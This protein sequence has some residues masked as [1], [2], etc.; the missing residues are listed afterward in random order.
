MFSIAIHRG[1]NLLECC[2]LQWSAVMSSHAALMA[3]NITSDVFHCHS[4]GKKSPWMLHLAM[5]S[6]D[7][8]T[9]SINGIQHHIWC[10]PLPCTG[11]KISLNAAHIPC[12][13]Q[14]WCPHMQHSWHPTETS[15]LVIYD[16]TFHLHSQKMV[17]IVLWAIYI[18]MLP[19]LIC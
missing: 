16:H 19:S 12:N 9:C 15:D 5:I 13:D 8:L 3:S 17:V 6:C 11:E 4:P 18:Y 1:K 7:V 14:L 10:F 2:T